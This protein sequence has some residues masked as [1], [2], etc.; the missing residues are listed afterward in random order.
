MS[1]TSIRP[2]GHH[3]VVEPIK[4]P[5][6]SKGGI[7]VVVEGGEQEKLEKAGRMIGTI[8]AVGPQ[9]WKA[10]RAALDHILESFDPAAAPWAE[11]GDTVLYSRH[12]GKYVFDPCDDPET[13]RELY[14]IHDDDVLA[15]LPPQSEWA[16]EY[17]EI[18]V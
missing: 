16:L 10:H 5:E 11:V 13:K 17:S 2:C 7:I 14:L 3:L 6:K 15:K 1:K 4:L 18:T 9:C 12:A 8:L